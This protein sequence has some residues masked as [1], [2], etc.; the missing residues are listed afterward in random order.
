MT[1]SFYTVSHVTLDGNSHYVRTFTRKANATKLAKLLAKNA[2][3]KESVVWLGG[4]GGDMV[5]VF[6]A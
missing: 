6:T 5:A 2:W 1:S 4:V 3:C